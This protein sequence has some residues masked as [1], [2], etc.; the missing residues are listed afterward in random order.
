[1]KT[2][3]NKAEKETSQVVLQ[4]YHSDLLWLFQAVGEKFRNFLSD[5]SSKV[6]L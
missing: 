2:Q 3:K 6:T 5:I 4:T 1:M